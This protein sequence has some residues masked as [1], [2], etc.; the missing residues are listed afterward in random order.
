VFLGSRGSVE[1]HGFE[2]KGELGTGAAIENL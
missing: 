2:D 1:E